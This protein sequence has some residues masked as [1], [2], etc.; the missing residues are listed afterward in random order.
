MLA[1]AIL[2]F[3][4]DIIE[5]LLNWGVCKA[6]A[7]ADSG[8][9]TKFLMTLGGP[10]PARKDLPIQLAKKECKEPNKY[11]EPKGKQIFGVQSN[12][13]I[14][15]TRIL[16]WRI[17]STKQLQQEYKIKLDAA[18]AEGCHSYTRASA[19]RMTDSGEVALEFCQ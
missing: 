7:A 15:P 5:C 13:L 12:N 10:A 18:T 3:S 16:Q 9:W 14:V 11:G 19:V 17:L 6:H 2:Q 1:F 4:F 8:D